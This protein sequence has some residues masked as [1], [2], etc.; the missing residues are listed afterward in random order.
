MSSSYDT[1]GSSE[2]DQIRMTLPE[3]KNFDEITEGSAVEAQSVENFNVRQ[4]DPRNA[5]QWGIKGIAKELQSSLSGGL[6]DTA[7]S[8][9]TFG[10][11]T[12]DAL[13]GERQREIEE[14][15]SY[16]PDWDPC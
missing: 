6:Q 14:T 11:R 13:S 3:L 9:T 12:I 7:S 2:L 8:V 1:S 5:D 10:E 15:G 4:E 16:T